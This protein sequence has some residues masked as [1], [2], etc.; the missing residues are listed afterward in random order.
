MSVTAL[1]EKLYNDEGRRVGL[2]TVVRQAKPFLE[3]VLHAGTNEE[4]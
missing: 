4:V 3:G 2:S 1:S